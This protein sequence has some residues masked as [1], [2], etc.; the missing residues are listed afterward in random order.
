MSPI[1]RGHSLEFLSNSAAQT[2]RAGMRLGELLRVGD[3]VCLTGDLGSGKTTLTQGI[4][5][6]WGSSDQVSSPT[7]VLVNVYRKPN[8]SSLYHLDA[9]RL[10][11][12]AEA[13]DLD[14]DT[15]LDAGPMVVEWAD[16]IETA[17]P[18]ECLLIAFQWKDDERRSLIFTAKGERY[19]H[20]IE[21]FRQRIY[22]V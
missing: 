19:E 4:A 21:S 2:R 17:L 11:G 6:G 15:M 9:Y 12:P 14:L 13:D 16:R 10:S 7:F 20:L 1:F 3:L 18:D 22:A 5:A 8:G